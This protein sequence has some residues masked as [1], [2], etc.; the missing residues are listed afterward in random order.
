MRKPRWW[1][2][3]IVVALVCT[4]LVGTLAY[5]SYRTASMMLYN[6]MSDSVEDMMGSV[7]ESGI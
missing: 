4:V 2:E 3:L 5:V 1:V 7:H 6:K